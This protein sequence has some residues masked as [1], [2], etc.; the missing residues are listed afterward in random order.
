[1][2]RASAKAWVLSASV[3]VPP[4]MGTMS[5]MMELQNSITLYN[6]FHPSLMYWLMG[7]YVPKNHWPSAP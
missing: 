1:M 4:Q 6:P 7:V 5:W 3:M 2:A